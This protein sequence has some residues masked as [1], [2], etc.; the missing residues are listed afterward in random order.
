M[1]VFSKTDETE[2]SDNVFDN[3]GYTYFETKRFEAILKELRTDFF[4]VASASF[5][6]KDLA[7][8]T[9]RVPADQA[10]SAEAYALR[11]NVGWRLASSSESIVIEED[12]DYKPFMKVYTFDEP[13]E[14]ADAKGVVH[15]RH[16]YVI[17][18]SIAS[19]S[20][21]LDDD[22]LIKV[23]P[24]LYQAVTAWKDEEYLVLLGLEEESLEG[25]G[26]PRVLKALDQLSPTEIEKIKP[27]MYEEKKV[28]KLL[29]RYA[30][31]DEI[32]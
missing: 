30:N 18:R 21:V 12:P 14:I 9:V 22:R 16:G 31:E 13:R 20:M 27:F 6:A 7:R 4:L 28:I 1:P 2:R 5:E 29:V 8:K 17:T 26:W 32:E 11:Y 19:G 25:T 3:I 23:D 15:T 10:E 24:D